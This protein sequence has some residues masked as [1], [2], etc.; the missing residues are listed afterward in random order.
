MILKANAIV[1]PH[2]IELLYAASQAGVQVDLL[3]R[4][5][6]CLRPGIKGI[7]ENIRVISVVGRFLEHSRIYYF[8]NGGREE[9]YIGSADL[10]TRNLNHRVEVV[11]PVE[12]KAH[13]HYLRTEVLETY[14]KDN[15]RSR[16]M[17][18]NGSYVHLRPDEKAEPVNIQQ[19]LMDHRVKMKA[20]LHKK[21]KKSKKS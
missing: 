10:M 20:A 16:V 21:E 3:I 19:W 14:L 18:S 11:F 4:G 15:S 2:M 13:I 5:I 1:D 17:Q 7:S 9:I 12:N 6:C 8:Q